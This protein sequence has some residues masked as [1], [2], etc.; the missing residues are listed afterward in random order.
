[1]HKLPGDL[2]DGLM[3]SQ[4][5][6]EAWKDITPLAR[7]EFICWVEDAKQPKLANDAFV[8]HVKSLKKDS[9]GR[10]AGPAVNTANVTERMASKGTIL[11]L[12]TK[13]SW[14]AE[15]EAYG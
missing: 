14:D 1:M 2:R 8:E 13:K 10:A 4:S 12:A 5:A 15:S 11:L 7:N 3:T 6:L 9:A